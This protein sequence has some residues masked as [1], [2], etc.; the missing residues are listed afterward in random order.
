MISLYKGVKQQ[1][2]NMKRWTPASAGREITLISLYTWSF[3]YLANSIGHLTKN[4]KRHEAPRRLPLL[5]N[6]KR[7]RAYVFQVLHLIIWFLLTTF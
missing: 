4:F 6:V 7:L 3:V 1:M 5:K 2:D